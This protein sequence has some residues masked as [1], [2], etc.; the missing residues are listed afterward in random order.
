MSFKWS[1][2]CDHCEHKFDNFQ[3]VCEQ[4][5]YIFFY[6]R[7]KLITS[8]SFLN[9]HY[10]SKDFLCWKERS[11]VFRVIKILRLAY[12]KIEKAYQRTLKE[13]HKKNTLIAEVFCLIN[14]CRS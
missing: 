14:G 12:Q 6:Y 10:K 2:I 11:L 7:N 9:V 8:G 4:A 1:F 13:G 3:F 5:S